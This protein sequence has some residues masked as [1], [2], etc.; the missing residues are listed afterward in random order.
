MDAQQA[1]GALGALGF[2]LPSPAYLLGALLFGIYGWVAYRHGKKTANG[3]VRWTGL[4]LMLYPYAVSETWM[5][6]LLGVALCGW[7]WWKWE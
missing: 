5:L 1:A 6:W 3:Q 2:A 4:A 7:V